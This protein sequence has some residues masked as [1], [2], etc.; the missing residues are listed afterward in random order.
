MGTDALCFS[1]ASVHALICQSC[2]HVLTRERGSRLQEDRG[3]ATRRGVYKLGTSSDDRELG[4]A[5]A[6]PREYAG[7]SCDD[8]W[9]GAQSSHARLSRST[10]DAG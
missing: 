9:V 10:L 7:G 1:V 2:R 5:R 6:V 8:Q 3:L 4:Q